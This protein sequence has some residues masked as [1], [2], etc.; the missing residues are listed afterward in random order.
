MSS[1]IYLE[2]LLQ[3]NVRHTSYSALTPYVE[4]VRVWPLQSA[5]QGGVRL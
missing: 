1:F 5:F 2:E 4:T 3:N